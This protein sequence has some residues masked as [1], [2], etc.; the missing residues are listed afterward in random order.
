VSTA[1][2]TSAFPA[3][4]SSLSAVRRWLQVEVQDA[5]YGDDLEDLKLAVTEA[6][7]NAIRH[8]GSAR[9]IVSVAR[10]ERCVEVT[11][12]DHGVFNDGPAMSDGDS[13]RG[14]ALIDAVVDEVW[15]QRG[16]TVSKGTVL[17]MRKCP[18]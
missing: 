18:A 16:T 5:L 13:H 8:S 4:A 3:E 12:E 2:T 17:R 7:A 11:V 9:F 1:G 14:L 6:C 15:I 10:S